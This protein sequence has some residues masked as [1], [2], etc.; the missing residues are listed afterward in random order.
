[1]NWIP[2]KRGDEE[3][4]TKRGWKPRISFDAFFS[5]FLSAL[6]TLP[7]SQSSS[8]FSVN[9]GWTSLCAL[10]KISPLFKALFEARKM[11]GGNFKKSFIH[12]VVAISLIMI[13]VHVIILIFNEFQFSGWFLFGGPLSRIST[14]AQLAPLRLFDAIAFIKDLIVWPLNCNE[15]VTALS[16]D[17]YRWSKHGVTSSFQLW[18]RDFLRCV[19]SLRNVGPSA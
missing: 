11:Y 1:M 12:H 8:L 15:R 17:T 4:V 16:F 10:S 7:S 2:Y 18:E 19:L 3:G 14:L 9:K 5:S 6:S 13:N